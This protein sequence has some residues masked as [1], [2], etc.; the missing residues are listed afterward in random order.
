MCAYAD[1]ANSDSGVA[2]KSE[3]VLDLVEQFLVALIVADDLGHGR[4]Q[5]IE[6]ALRERNS[7]SFVSGHGGVPDLV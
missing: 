1:W 2:R 6:Q 4:A 7:M 3:E 5:H